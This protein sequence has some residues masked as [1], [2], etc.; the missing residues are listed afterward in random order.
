MRLTCLPALLPLL[1]LSCSSAPSTAEETSGFSPTPEFSQYWQQGKAELTSYTLEQARYGEMRPG[2]AV[3]VFV[4]EDLSRTRQVKLDNP[5]ATPKDALPV[6][7]LNLSKKFLTGIYPYSILTSVFTPLNPKLSTVKVSTSVQEWCGNAF[8]QLNQRG[9]GYALSQKSYFESEGDVENKL[10]PA[11]LEDGLW[12]QIRLHPEALPQG[13]Q[14][15]IPSTI[16]C[17][18]QHQPLRPTPATLTLTDAPAGKL[19]PAPARAYTV[20]YPAPLDRTLVIYFTQAFPHTILGWEETYPDRAGTAQPVRLTT[21]A[22]RR[23]TILLDYWRTHG[24]A[25]LR[26]RDSLSLSR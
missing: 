1:L 17:R 9:A 13:P 18:L 7:K 26:W 3:L 12:N 25:D 19:G 11:V 2:E 6:L 4:T 22:T 15:L 21:R 16:Y 8:T 14:Q 20:R 23:K 5:S 10:G 24:N